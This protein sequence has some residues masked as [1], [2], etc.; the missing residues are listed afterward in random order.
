[1]FAHIVGEMALL[2]DYCDASERYMSFFECKLICDVWDYP[3]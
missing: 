2:C 1:M 3:W